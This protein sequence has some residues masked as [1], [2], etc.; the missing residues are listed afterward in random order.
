[1]SNLTIISQDL[2]DFLQTAGVSDLT[3][4]LAGR[5]GVKRI[6]PKNGIFRKMVGGEEMGKVKGNLSAIIVNASPHVGRIFYAKAWSPDAEPT[7]PDCFSNDGR[8]PASG[9]ANPQ[10]E[11]CDNCQQNIK[12]SGMGNSKACRYSRRIAMVLEEDFGTS[13]EGEVYQMNLASK[14]LFGEGAGD[15]THTFENYSKYLSNNGKSL[16]YVV[17]QISFNEENDNQSVM[18]TPTGYINKAQYAVTSEVAKK[19]EVLKMVVMT[20]YQAD[21]S[22]KVAKLEAPAPA[23]AP[24][25]ESPI[26]EP[27][28]RE[29]KVEPKPSVKKDLDSVVKAW[30]DEE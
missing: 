5:A 19:P 12:G 9:A 21:V 1:M 8:T 10:A 22:G 6:V 29:K 26:E 13:L 28:K 16:D 14:S 25:V 18:F 2:P 17:T 15:N 4:Q 3:K 20:P 7:A 27:T 30:S 24:K 23:P 11:R